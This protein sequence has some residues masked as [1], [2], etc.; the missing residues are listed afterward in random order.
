MIAYHDFVPRVT[1]RGGLFKQA[2]FDTL[3]DALHEAN[4]WIGERHLKVLNVETVVLP[5]MHTSWEEGSEDA[6]LRT[7]GEI[8]AMWHQFIRVWYELPDGPPPLA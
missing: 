1:D 3:R 5:N 4:A 6:S 7:S 8:S 2:Q